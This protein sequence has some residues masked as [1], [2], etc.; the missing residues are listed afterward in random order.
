MRRQGSI[1]GSSRRNCLVSCPR[2]PFSHLGE[3]GVPNAAALKPDGRFAPD[4]IV[5]TV[6]AVWA[7]ANK[8]EATAAEGLT[9]LCLGPLT[10]LALALEKDPALPSKVRKVICIAGSFGFA[11]AGTVRATGNNPVSEWNACVDPEAADRVA[12]AGFGRSETKKKKNKK[13]VALGLHVVAEG[14]PRRSEAEFLLGV[15]RFGAS[16]GFPSYCCLIDSVAVAT[17]L[18]DSVVTLEEIRVAVETEGRHSPGQTIVDRREHRPW[19]HLPKR[20]AA[21]D[22]DSKRYLDLLVGA[23]A[24]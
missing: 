15:V 10:N 8:G 18:D 23:V 16:R 9:I 4:V 24:G 12:N 3:L 5:E 7:E 21:S 13:L 20:L 11:V 6:D 19:L 1:R 14:G 17:A 22:I 2:D